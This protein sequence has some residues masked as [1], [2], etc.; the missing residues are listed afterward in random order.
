MARQSFTPD[1]NSMTEIDTDDTPNGVTVD[2]DSKDPDAFEIVIEDDTP[3]ADR[4][5]PRHLDYSI[6][7]QEED[8][9]GVADKTRKRIE[10]LKFETNTER[11]AREA[12]EAQRDAAVEVA[13]IARQEVEDLRRRTETGTSALAASMLARNK[14]AMDNAQRRMSDAHTDGDSAKFAEATTEIARLSAER[15]AIESRA[16]KE[17]K[18][19]AA[20]PE[21]QRQQEAQPARTPM[22]PNVTAWLSQNRSWFQQPGN[23]AKTSQAMSI[24]YDLVARGV[25]TDSP[26]Y[27]RQLDKRL[28]AVY[29][30]HQS[31]G[32]DEGVDD[33]RE[34]RREPRRTT[35][36]AEGSREDN[37]RQPSRKVSLT[38][39]QVAIAKKLGVPLQKYAAELQRREQMGKGDGA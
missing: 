26:E 14:E 20:Q 31:F 11:R 8:L 3:E 35:V 7:E 21:P 38:S 15:L 39:S 36:V 9:R 10:R 6:A 29:P 13:R 19:G 28:K 25:R 16:P 5:K 23:E 33:G 17:P 12:A 24:H 34:A 32:A 30:E 27:T 2:L 4:G 1:R 22:P 37:T 18:P